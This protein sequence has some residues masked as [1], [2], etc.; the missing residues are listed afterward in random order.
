MNKGSKKL[1]TAQILAV[2]KMLEENVRSSETEGMV[3]YIN[4]MNDHKIAE[5]L[6]LPSHHGVARIRNEMFGK[7]ISMSAPVSGTSAES[8]RK[9]IVALERYLDKLDPD[10]RKESDES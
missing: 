4:G 1:T 10:W 2:H 7:L 8:L 3:Y 5:E 6:E 9:R